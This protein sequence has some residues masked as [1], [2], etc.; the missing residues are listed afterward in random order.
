MHPVMQRGG[1]YKTK[2]RNKKTEEDKQKKRGVRA[3]PLTGQPSSESGGILP[4]TTNPAVVRSRLSGGMPA[5]LTVVD[6]SRLSNGGGSM[7]SASISSASIW[8]RDGLSGMWARLKSRVPG[9]LLASLWLA[10]ARLES[11]TSREASRSSSRD[12]SERAREVPRFSVDTASE[13]TEVGLE[14]FPT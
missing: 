4:S 10:E 7:E 14:S 1:T 2:L 9:R 11:E 3:A 6:G 5:V 13:M 8:R 12:S